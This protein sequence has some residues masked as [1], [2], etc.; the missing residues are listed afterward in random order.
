LAGHAVQIAF[1]GAHSGASEIGLSV[2]ETIMASLLWVAG[3]ANQAAS[4]EIMAVCLPA[5]GVESGEA[6]IGRMNP[7]W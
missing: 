1:C 3:A 4:A 6:V 5:P 7:K 2:T